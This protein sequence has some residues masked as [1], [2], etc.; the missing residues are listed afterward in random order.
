MPV[1]TA[2]GAT[3][4]EGERATILVRL[5]H[6][7]RRP[8]TVRFRTMPGSAQ[9]DADYTS[10][11]GTLTFRSGQRVQRIRIA[12]IDDAEAEADET[13]GVAF[14]RVRG[15]RLGTRRATVRIRRS[16]LPA[17]FVLHADMSGAEEPANFAHPTGQG[18]AVVTFD[19]EA[20]KIN[21]D[22]R[23]DAME[24][25]LAGICRGAPFELGTDVRQ[26]EGRFVGGRL[27]GTVQLE[28][29]SILEIHRAPERFC[30]R[31]VDSS[32]QFIR[33]YFRRA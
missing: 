2:S 30:A 32:N 16:D 19:P 33:G 20:E 28:L 9:P 27:S 24:P 12:T 17:T 8:V 22:V 11:S 23:I 21:Y 5:S 7:S 6:A 10:Q 15:A 31:S 1:V 26:F 29:A 4:S 25:M 3:A 13:L 18:T 14:T